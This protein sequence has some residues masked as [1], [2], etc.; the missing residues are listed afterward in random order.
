[1]QTTRCRAATNLKG[2]SRGRIYSTNASFP[3]RDLMVRALL[4]NR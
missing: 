1:K 2:N 3:E 4:Q